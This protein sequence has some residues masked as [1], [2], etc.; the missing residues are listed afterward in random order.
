MKKIVNSKVARRWRVR[1]RIRKHLA[2]TLERP[3]L[4]IFKSNTNIYVQLIDDVQGHTLLASS[5]QQLKLKQNN[6]AAALALGRFIAEQAIAKG[7][8]TVVLDR[9]GY[10]YHGKVRAIAEGAREKGLKF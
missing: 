9:S 4:S 1:Q 7:I 2:G 3:R 5:L 6:V 10:I 8:A